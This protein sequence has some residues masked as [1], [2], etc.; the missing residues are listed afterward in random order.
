MKIVTSAAL[1]ILASM[2]G[3][4]FG[5][6]NVVPMPTLP[7]GQP[8]E[9]RVAYVVNARLPRMTPAQLQALLAA[10][11]ATAREHFGVDIRFSRVEEIPIEKL[12]ARMIPKRAAGHSQL[13]YDFKGGRGDFDRFAKAFAKDLTV[14]G[15]QLP[16]LIEYARPHIGTIPVESYEA[17]GTALARLQLDRLE[18]W[19]NIKAL[20]G[21]PAIDGN[22]YNEF[23]MWLALGY[24]DVPFELLLTN[25]VIAS[26]EYAHST[27][28]SA[29]RGG[30]TN[31]VVTYSRQSRL[32][33]VAVWST[34]AYTTD[35]P[36]VTE[37]RGGESYSAEEAARLAGIG[38][39][40]ELG[41]QL[42]HILHPYGRTACLMNPVPMFAYRAWVA[43]LSAKD[44][45]IGS[46]PDMRPGAFKY[47]YDR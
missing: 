21:K 3:S 41:H 14:H 42:F 7:Q 8:I 36:W 38:A 24:S 26:V 12:F 16:E 33:T 9:M 32:G 20:D 27:V 13:I 18:R 10:T 11:Q 31:G 28:H 37:M 2:A 23:H 25:Q 45:P 46:G 39:T 29:I 4:V 43:G 15:G 19:R 34:F 44:C 35:D 30:Y 1:L 47:L 22:P 5:A 40:H 17:L 6:A